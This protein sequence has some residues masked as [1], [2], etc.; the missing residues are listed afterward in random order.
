MKANDIFTKELR[1]T[2]AI[3]NEDIIIYSKFGQQN[4]TLI[5]LKIFKKNKS[6]YKEDELG[7]SRIIEFDEL[8]A[9][10]KL[11]EEIQNG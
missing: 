6:F 7:N 1:Y 2:L 3:E 4:K 9:I 5:T 8:K 10:N 11:M